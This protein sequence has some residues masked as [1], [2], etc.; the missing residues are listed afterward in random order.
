ML[1]CNKAGNIGRVYIG[2]IRYGYSN[3]TVRNSK[4]MLIMYMVK[5][6]CAT[7]TLGNQKEKKSSR[8]V[9]SKILRKMIRTS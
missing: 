7:W 2:E 4:H 3:T 6:R 5:Y 1:R 8:D 9:V